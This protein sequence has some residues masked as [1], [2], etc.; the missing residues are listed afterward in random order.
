MK[1]QNEIFLLAVLTGLAIVF[2]AAALVSPIDTGLR[3]AANDQTLSGQ[4]FSN[5]V[6]PN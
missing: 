4:Y 5:D 2:V 1:R 6:L 3:I